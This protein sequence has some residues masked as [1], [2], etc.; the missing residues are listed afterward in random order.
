M[1]QRNLVLFSTTMVVLLLSSTVL[2][3]AQ[4]RSW[5][6]F[7]ASK[8][9]ATKL[10]RNPQTFPHASTD[11]GHIVHKTPVAIFNPSS[12]S[13]ILALIH[14]SNSLPNPFP[15]APRGKA[16]SVHG[17]AMTKDGVVLNMTN[18]NSSQNGSGIL[19]SACDGKSPLVCY[20]DVG[21]GQMWIDVFH[22][23]LQRGLTP[24][25]L[26]DYMYATIGGTLSNAGMDGMAFRFGPQISN[27]L[28]LDVVTGMTHSILSGNLSINLFH[29]HLHLCSM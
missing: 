4:P 18:L 23:A 28:Q 2:T 27:V 6:A 9:L 25:S 10:S 3:Q 20:V 11:Y 17:Q 29:N 14:F 8:E 7:Q 13:D 24:L 15:I 16:H 1:P 19:V 26:T 22:A 5:T 21:G 12:V